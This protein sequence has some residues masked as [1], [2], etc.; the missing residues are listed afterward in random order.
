[1]TFINQPNQKPTI[2]CSPSNIFTNL[3]EAIMHSPQHFQPCPIPG[4]V[5]AKNIT[6]V[7]TV[8][9]NKQSSSSLN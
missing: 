4:G 5:L 7:Q 8:Q 9:I 2:T 3:K 1:M 6:T